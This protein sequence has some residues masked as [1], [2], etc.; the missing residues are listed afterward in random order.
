LTPT[1]ESELGGF[2]AAVGFHHDFDQWA[3]SRPAGNIQKT[4]NRSAEGSLNRDAPC[5]GEF[6]PIRPVEDKETLKRIQHIACG[7]GD[8]VL[9]DN[10]IPHS[11]SRENKANGSVEEF[12]RL[13]GRPPNKDCV[14]SGAREVVY[15]GFL[16]DVP[17]N[18]EYAAAQLARFKSGQ[19]PDDQWREHISSTTTETLRSSEQINTST[20]V[21]VYSFSRL[22]RQLMAMDSWI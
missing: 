14:W 1:P 17:L 15:L 6:T 13:W 16:P 5:V 7:A 18:R 3:R 12:E 9:W 20:P 11:N 8:L 22:G 2:E 21:S 10:R 19:P 4:T